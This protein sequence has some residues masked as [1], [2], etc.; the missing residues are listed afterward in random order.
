MVKADNTKPIAGHY[1][2]NYGNF[3]S[4]IYSAIRQEAFG[5]DIGQNSWLTRDEQDRF[6]EHLALSAG[7]KLLDVGCGAGGP[8]LQIAEKTGC[9][10]LGIDVHEQAIAAARSLATKLG[11]ADRV[12]FRVVNASGR[13]VSADGEFDAILCIDAINHLPDRTAV[14]G[15]WARVLKPGGRL[16]FTDP[17]TLTGPMSKDEIAS[18]SSAGFFLFVPPGYDRQVLAE[19]GFRLLLCED[20]TENMSQIAQKRLLARASREEALRKIEG[21]ADFEQQQRFLEVAARVARERRL[22]R[23][24]YVAEKPI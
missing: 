11:L 12:N 16:L 20:V 13:L 2:A 18:R 14:I 9:S 24:L 4:E 8:G 19:C 21:D 3:E 7:K 22:S 15:D 6:I 23:F 17:I 1:D 5:E 10:V